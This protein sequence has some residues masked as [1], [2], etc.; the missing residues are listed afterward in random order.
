MAHRFVF[1]L[2]L[3]VPSALA[4]Q[5]PRIIGSSL[6][7]QIEIL[8]ELPKHRVDVFVDNIVKYSRV[9]DLDPYLVSSIIYVESRFKHFKSPTEHD[10]GPMQVNKFWFKK[11]GIA[12]KDVLDI[13]GGI[14]IGTQI[15]AMNKKENPDDTCWWSAYNSKNPASRKKYEKKVLSTMRMF[16]KRLSC[17]V[18]L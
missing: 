13:A 14:K 7:Q 9:N 2:L 18:S 5:T 3:F 10:F 17:E 4:V 1:I 6:F 16:G 15:L 11:L 12:E 8:S